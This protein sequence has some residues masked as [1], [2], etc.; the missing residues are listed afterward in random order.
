MRISAKPNHPSNGLLLRAD[1][2][3][4]FDLGLLSIDE[5]TLSVILSDRLKQSMYADLAGKRLRLPSDTLS[6]P[7]PEAIRQH[8][9]WAAL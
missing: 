2:H 3:T 7:S 1:L 5:S 4:L 9:R 8:R 6:Y